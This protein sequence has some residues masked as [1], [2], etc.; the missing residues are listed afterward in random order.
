MRGRTPRI[1]GTL[2]A[3]LTWTALAADPGD[4]NR[5]VSRMTV[6]VYDFANVG[7]KTLAQSEQLANRIFALAEVDAQWTAGSRSDPNALMNDFRAAEQAGCDNVLPAVLQVQIFSH[8]PLGSPRKRLGSRYRAR[9]E[10]CGSP[11]LPTAS[12]L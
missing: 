11:Y 1:L 2:M 12:N 10:A 8:G 6:S 3:T 5:S 4:A 7:F 9:T